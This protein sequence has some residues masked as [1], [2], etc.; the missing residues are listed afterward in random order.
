[1]SLLLDA[2]KEAEKSRKELKAT[3]E[4]GSPAEN[5][6]IFLDL[7]IEEPEQDLSQTKGSHDEQPQEKPQEQESAPQNSAPNQATTQATTTPDISEPLNKDSETTPSPNS[8]LE[9]DEEPYIES[10]PKETTGSKA[11]PP[12]EEKKSPIPATRPKIENRPRVAASVFKNQ[13][14]I[15]SQTE[16]QQKSRVLILLL[17]LL[18]VLTGFVGMYF[19]LS[20]ES[21]PTFPQPRYNTQHESITQVVGTGSSPKEIQTPA[22]SIAPSTINTP[23]TTEENQ[24]A[25]ITSDQV[26]PNKPEPVLTN[27]ITPAFENQAATNQAILDRSTEDKSPVS[28][29]RQISS[30]K[31]SKASSKPG[32]QISKRKLSPRSQSSLTA[33]KQA[34]ISGNLESAETAYRRALKESP[35]NITAMSSLASLLVQQ[36]RVQ[37]A[38][39]LFLKTL[40]KDPE[41]LI[42]KTGLINIRA[43][44]PSNLSAGSE[45]KQLLIEHPKQAHLH[46]SLGNFHAQ[47]SEWPAAQAAYFE[48]FALDSTSPDYAF[49]LA[50][51]LDQIGKPEIA[52]NYYKKA[53]ELF[54]SRPSQFS[55][56]DAE[57][58]LEEL[59]G[60]NE[61]NGLKQLEGTAP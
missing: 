38:Q 42:A 45:L 46:A 52:A 47:R 44:G 5:Q 59:K 12:T 33:A 20:A 18:L 7:D 48:A 55:R 22:S 53:I 56:A 32:I 4:P 41:N 31:P 8:R 58:R 30:N 1:L 9:L 37:E 57:R 27:T 34:L 49:N 36:G 15:S 14:P 11:T 54:G 26:S 61:L 25:S 17:L 2:L 29:D 50:I 35:G 60:F 39:I 3:D 24:A 19:I 23:S 43:A 16:P 28:S 21:E 51:S 6:E 40:E 10:T 13:E